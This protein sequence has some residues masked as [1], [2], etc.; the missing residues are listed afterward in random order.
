MTMQEVKC[1]YSVL[2]DTEA[3]KQLNISSV[4]INEWDENRGRV[5]IANTPQSI[6]RLFFLHT[7]D[8]DVFINN[9]EKNGIRCYFDPNDKI[10]VPGAELWILNNQIYVR[11]IFE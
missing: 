1:L 2:L 5:Y 3:L 10:C 8:V 7:W 4:N 6:A 9:A 11:K